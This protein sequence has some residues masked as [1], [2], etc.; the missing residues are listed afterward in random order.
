MCEY[1][2]VKYSDLLKTQN[3]QFE[4]HTLYRL[5]RKLIR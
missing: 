5:K 2:T 3:G 4:R 1:T